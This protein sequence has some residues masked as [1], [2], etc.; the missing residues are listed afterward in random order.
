MSRKAINNGSY[1][2]NLLGTVK[3]NRNNMLSSH[4]AS[5]VTNSEIALRFPREASDKDSS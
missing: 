2:Q 5:G 1:I 3:E 4:V